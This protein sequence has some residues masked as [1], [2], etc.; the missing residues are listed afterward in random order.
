MAKNLLDSGCSLI[1]HDMYPEAVADL[2]LLGAETASTP[3]EVA[4]RTKQIVTMLPSS[5]NVEE[6]YAGEHGILKSVQEGTLLIDSSTIDP[7]VSKNM[8]AL[9]KDKGAIYLDAPVSG[10]VNAAKTA[11]LTFMV[12]GKEAG[13]EEAKPI[14]EQMGKNVVHTGKVGTGQAAKICNNMLLAISMIGVSEAM[15]LGIRLGLDPSMMAEII[16]SSSGRCWSSDTYNPCPGVMPGVPSSNNYQGGFGT[17]LMAKDLGLAQNAA[18]STK[19]ATPLGSLAHQM[20]RIMCN[21]GYS[22]LDFGSV[23]KFLKEEQ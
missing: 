11:V 21:K 13:F 23:F 2:K 10:G 18:T 7:T 6:V 19:T 20:Y 17:A 8:A 16:N 12:G 9:A 14:L 4:S 1:V 15:N 5:P 3:S 22:K